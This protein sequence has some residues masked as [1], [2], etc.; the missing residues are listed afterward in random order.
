MESVQGTVLPSLHEA[1]IMSY[2]T[3]VWG[4]F[5]VYFSLS[6]TCVMRVCMAFDTPT[7]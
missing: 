5:R 7:S 2:G 6:C 1:W 4:R 3:V